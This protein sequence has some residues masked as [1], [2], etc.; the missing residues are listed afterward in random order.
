MR[1]SRFRA[2]S[3]LACVICL[4]GGVGL[5]QQA[6]EPSVEAVALLAKVEGVIGP[7]NARFVDVAVQ[8]ADAR[9]AHVLVLQMDTPGGLSTSMRE[10]IESIL[11]SQT[12]V[13]G[14]VAPQ[15]GRAASAGTYIL[16]ATHI[17][18]MAPGTNIGAATPVQIGGAPDLPDFPDNDSDEGE[19][20]GE[21]AGGEADEEPASNEAGDNESG[22]DNAA[23]DDI[24]FNRG[25][26]Q[27]GCP[28]AEPAPPPPGDA[29]S[30]KAVNDAVAYIRSL[31]ELRGR[32]AEW[33][34]CA[35]RGAGSITPRE[36]LEL[37]VIEFVAEDI[38]D[39]LDQI[40]G[41]TVTIGGNEFELATAGLSVQEIEPSLITQILG[42]IANPNVAF[43]FMLVGVYGLIFELAQPGSIGPGVIGLI[44]LVIGLYALNQLP[45][46]YA[47]AALV[48]IGL[49]FM[50]V[51]AVTPTFGV[52]GIGGLIAFVIGGAMLFDTDIP[53]FRLSPA[54]I[55]ATA[56]A[57]GGLLILV[58]GYVWRSFRAPVATG[59]QR[60]L[61]EPTTVLDWAGSSGHVMVEGERWAAVSAESLS[62]G[63]EAYV[64]EV[65]GLTVHVSSVPPKRIRRR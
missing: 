22:L 64:T 51:E 24:G 21:D 26:G 23:G 40:D 47:G 15:G 39:L 61:G 2:L 53:E 5:A 28:R 50:A 6:E 30:A 20:A 34:E 12:P 45:L 42:A 58:L 27:Q 37:N 9:G 32:N 16:Y 17:A 49:I 56:A 63:D 44:C 48:T 41:Q 43:I 31:A 4:L 59:L 19:D 65:D 57:S 13:I 8:E 46:N 10:I 18:A 62:V 60:M 14:Y 35:V 1:H 7:A 38:E 29:L 54:V 52:F 55:A 25:L 11:A 36:A 3:V 33:A